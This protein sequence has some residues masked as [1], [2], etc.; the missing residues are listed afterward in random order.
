MKI[1]IISRAWFT[2]VK[3]GAE[4]Y[5]YEVTKELI[6][7]GHE[8]TTISRHESDLPNRHVIIRL[9]EIPIPISALSSLLFSLVSGLIV[10]LSEHKVVIVNGYW[11]EFS[12]F[13]LM[14]PC[15]V[16]LHDVGLFNSKLA[17]RQRMKHFLRTIILRQLV[18]KAKK[19][20]VPSKLTFNEIKISLGV[21][22]K[23][24]ELVPE[25]IDLG[26]FKPISKKT[27][28]AFKI[29]QFGRFAPNKGQEVLIRA[30]NIIHAR[31]PATKLYLVGYLGKKYYT[32][33]NHLMQL[34]KGEEDIIFKTNV[35]EEEL[36]KL[37]NQ[38]DICVF[39]SVG[40]E[41]WG[42]T[43]AEAFACRIPVVCT[44]IFFETGVADNSRALLAPTDVDKLAERILWAI[45][46][47]DFMERL[48]SNG[49]EWVQNL[50][51]KKTANRIVEIIEVLTRNRPKQK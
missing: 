10:A 49:Y 24:L 40:E 36:I 13:L 26:K 45:D 29:F 16:I 32:Y 46:H 21:S 42:L 1:A 14:K 39:P 28:E 43:L 27:N 51:W 2:E 50:S 8:V 33:F 6:R 19:I 17:Q 3:G 30:F 25:G 23:K 9:P 31:Y 48:A 34:A 44:R 18:R 41:G 47:R 11:A 35:S 5:T 4:R 12:P 38:A 15:I 7:L 20:I 37:Y 22:E